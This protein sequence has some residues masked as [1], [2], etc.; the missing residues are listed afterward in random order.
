MGTA[1]KHAVRPVPDLVEPSFVIFD[2]RALWRLG[3]ASEG[4]LKTVKVVAF[5]WIFNNA[6]NVFSN[7]YSLI[8]RRLFLHVYFQILRGFDAALLLAGTRNMSN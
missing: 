1:I 4:R 5:F 2:I 3:T 8:L 6:E 7:K